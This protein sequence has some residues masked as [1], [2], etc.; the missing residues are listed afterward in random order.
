MIRM[1]MDVGKVDNLVDNELSIASNGFP[2]LDVDNNPLLAS[3][4][5]GFPHFS[6][7]VE[8]DVWTSFHHHLIWKTNGK[9]VGE[10]CLFPLLH[11]LGLKM[12]KN[13]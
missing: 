13:E 7:L 10:Y 3:I 12:W 11:L 1:M 9:R 2:I 6:D 4:L 5:C 8:N